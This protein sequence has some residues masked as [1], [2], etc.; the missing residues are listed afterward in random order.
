MQNIVCPY[1]VPSDEPGRLFC[2]DSTRLH[3][4]VTL[5]TPEERLDWCTTGRHGACPI[6]SFQE[7]DVSDR[8]DLGGGD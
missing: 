2:C 5:P 7:R 6:F 3:G 1:Y 8:F 4:A